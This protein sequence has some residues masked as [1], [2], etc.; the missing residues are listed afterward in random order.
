[1]SSQLLNEIIWLEFNR[2]TPKDYTDC[3]NLVGG[4]KLHLINI[5]QIQITTAM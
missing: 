5:Y 2:D 4:L 3:Q 1:M